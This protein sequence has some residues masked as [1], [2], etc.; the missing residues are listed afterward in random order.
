MTGDR[1]SFTCP[2]CN[3]TS[4]HPR[5]ISEGYCGACHAWTGD[6]VLVER[7]DLAI[8]LDSRDQLTDEE[9]AAY[10]RLLAA[11]AGEPG[12][13]TSDGGPPG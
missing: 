7:Q 11:A 12:P 3:R 2:R 13:K 8:M 6:R 9:W 10:W 1:P 4:Y 5:D